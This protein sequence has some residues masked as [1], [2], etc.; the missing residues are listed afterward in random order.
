MHF[1]L[2][3]PLLQTA[4]DAVPVFW[5]WVSPTTV[6]IVTANAVYHWSAAADGGDA[7]VK[8]FDRAANLAGTQVRIS[9]FTSRV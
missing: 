5:N 9:P 1:L 4:D 8:M 6:G 2:F 7:P 3:G